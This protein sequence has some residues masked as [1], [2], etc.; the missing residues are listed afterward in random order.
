MIED[1]NIPDET[2]KY[3]VNENAYNIVLAVEGLDGV[4]ECSCGCHT[5]QLA[6]NDT[7][8]AVPGNSL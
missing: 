4:E 2:R 6:I 1:I 7:F 3:V 8:N 5:L